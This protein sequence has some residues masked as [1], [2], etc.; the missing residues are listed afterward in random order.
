VNTVWRA[1]YWRSHGTSKMT[2]R[3]YVRRAFSCAEFG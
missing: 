2:R 3:A 1:W